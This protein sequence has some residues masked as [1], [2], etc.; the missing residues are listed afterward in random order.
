MICH[1]LLLD[2]MDVFCYILG[3]EKTG[4]GAV[5]DP[6]EDADRIFNK[7]QD[8]GLSLEYILNTHFHLDH[9]GAN[10]QLQALSGA[11]LAMHADDI[12]LYGKEVDITLQEGDRLPLGDL[13]I[14]VIH[15]PGHTPGGVSFYLQGNLFTGDTLFVKDSGRTDLPYSHRETLGASIRKLMELPAETLVFPGHDY[16][17]TPT[18]TLAREQ[19]HN[20]NAREYGFAV[21]Q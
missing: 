1:Q 8:L 5:I 3:C 17:P 10:L 11:K 18:S 21:Y 7:V 4:K 14:R 9:T 6:G 13:E 20:I 19:R 15:T 16:G 12:P 2:A